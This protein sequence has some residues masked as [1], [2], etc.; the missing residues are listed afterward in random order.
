MT[1][2]RRKKKSS[3]L[4]C[5]GTSLLVT[6]MLCLLLMYGISMTVYFLLLSHSHI[7]GHKNNPWLLHHRGMSKEEQLAKL[8]RLQL[9]KLQQTQKQPRVEEID[10]EDDLEMS[11]RNHKMQSIMRKHEIASTFQRK[12]PKMIHFL[13]IHKSAGTFLCKRAFQNKNGSSTG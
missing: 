8:N 10:E 12:Y 9:E 5:D 3:K 11:R 1:T 7:K 2:R 4:V 6:A 13:H